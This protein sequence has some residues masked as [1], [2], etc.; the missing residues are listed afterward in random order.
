MTEM[1]TEVIED[2]QKECGE[3]A[4]QRL[5]DRGNIDTSEMEA[6]IREAVDESVDKCDEVV[7]DDEDLSWM[8]KHPRFRKN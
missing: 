7:Y 6:M 4:V 1:P 5:A 3:T 2:L 8:D